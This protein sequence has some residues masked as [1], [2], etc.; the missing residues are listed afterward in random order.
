MED[1]AIVDLYWQRSDDAI[2]ESQRKY[3]NYCHA[4]A[5]KLVGDHRDAEECVNDTWLQ[6]WNLMPDKRPKLLSSFLGGICRGL[7]I[8]LYRTKT[9]KKRGGGEIPLVLEELADCIPSKSDPQREYQDREFAAAIS[10][11]V[12][13]LPETERRV[14]VARYWYLASVEDISR[15]AGFSVSKTKS[16]LLRIRDRLREYLREEGLC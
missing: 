1:S 4:I 13:R 16:M 6:A 10:R 9:S 14:F 3:G 8:S 11:F 2:Q 15:R 7:A 12:S 5:Y